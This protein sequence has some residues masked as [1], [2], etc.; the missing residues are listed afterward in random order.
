ME[1]LDSLLRQDCFYRIGSW[2]GFAETC[3][4]ANVVLS[5]L[6]Q[7]KVSLFKQIRSKIETL[8]N[9]YG[10]LTFASQSKTNFRSVFTTGLL[11]SSNFICI[12][13]EKIEYNKAN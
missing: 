13:E 7:Q 5:S 9:D 1:F 8:W 10:K 4:Q 2:I 3:V 6:I 12:I 11:I